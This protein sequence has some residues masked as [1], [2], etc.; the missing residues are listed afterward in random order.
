MQHSIDRFYKKRNSLRNSG[1][2]GYNRSSGDYDGWNG[3]SG[4]SN[5]DYNRRNS[6]RDDYDDDKTVYGDDNDG[7]WNDKGFGRSRSQP[8][9]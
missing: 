6:M 9:G 5:G 3:A 8:Y 4:A 2:N 7:S 1:G